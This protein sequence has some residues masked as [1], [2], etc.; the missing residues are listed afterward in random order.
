MYL[1]PNISLYFRCLLSPGLVPPTLFHASKDT[2][3]EICLFNTRFNSDT[4]DILGLVT[5]WEAVRGTS[6]IPSLYP[7]DE[8]ALLPRGVA[9]KN[10]SRY[11]QILL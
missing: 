3:L 6:S 1:I 4:I 5:V 2:H 11:Y 10:V 8:P 9:T 7:R